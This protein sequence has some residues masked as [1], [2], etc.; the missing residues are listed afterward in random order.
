MTSPVSFL[1]AVPHFVKQTLGF[2]EKNAIRKH[3][4]KNTVYS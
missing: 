1:N 3:S 4:G 2:P